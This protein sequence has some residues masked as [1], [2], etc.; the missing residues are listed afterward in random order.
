VI[1]M[2]DH[3]AGSGR[4]TLQRTTFFQPMWI[5]KRVA[6]EM[7][8]NFELKNP[9]KDF[10][11]WHPWLGI[12]PFAGSRS[13]LSGG[14]I[15]QAGDDLKMYMDWPEQYWDVGIW[16][17]SVWQDSPA[18][19][20]GV[21][22]KDVLYSLTVYKPD[23]NDTTSQITVVPYQYLKT[24]EQ[25]ETLITTAQKGYVFEFGVYHNGKLHNVDVEVK[26]R[27][28]NFLFVSATS[29]IN[30]EDSNEYL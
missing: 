28:D 3:Q 30:L 5:I 8:A 6:D 29:T 9:N 10:K 14:S 18:A 25:L 11:A 4:G 2:H 20:F 27:P 24:V 12:K 15:R 13:L 17:D 21:K 7:I 26:Q 19:E 23:P 22:A 16:I 1:G